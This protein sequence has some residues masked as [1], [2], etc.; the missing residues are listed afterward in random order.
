MLYKQFYILVIWN[1][2]SIAFYGNT[3]T[4]FGRI[5]KV[6]NTTLIRLVTDDKWVGSQT[7]HDRVHQRIF[8]L[9]TKRQPRLNSL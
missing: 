7:L 1:T 5:V 9:S 2:V 8:T 3:Q 4:D 6:G